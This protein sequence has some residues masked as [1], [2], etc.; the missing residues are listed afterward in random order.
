MQQIRLQFKTATP[1]FTNWSTNQR[2]CFIILSQ[3]ATAGCQVSQ[4]NRLLH[5]LNLIG[6]FKMSNCE[7]ELFFISEILHE[8]RFPTRHRVKLIVNYNWNRECSFYRLASLKQ[9]I[10]QKR[11]RIVHGSG[12]SIKTGSQR[13]LSVIQWIN[14]GAMQYCLI[15]SRI[16]NKYLC[17]SQYS[18]VKLQ[19]S[20]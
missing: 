9:L 10:A 20:I 11:D 1:D 18:Y 16:I 12:V 5:L 7:D 14:R 17:G 13:H 8:K 4:Q 6:N 15:Y 2:N 19:K 3:T